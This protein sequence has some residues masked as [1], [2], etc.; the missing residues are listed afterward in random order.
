MDRSAILTTANNKWIYPSRT[1]F[2]AQNKNIS[3]VQSKI[4]FDLL[5]LSYWSA[6]FLHKR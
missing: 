5:W 2:D 1:W 6:W 3:L 4:L